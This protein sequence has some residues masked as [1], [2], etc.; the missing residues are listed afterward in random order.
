MSAPLKTGPR[1]QALMHHFEGL[2][3]RA[4]L[5]PARVWTIGYGNTFYADG[6]PVRSGDSITHQ[7]A[8]EIF[9]ATLER[10]FEPGVQRA[11]GDAATTP[12][13]FG[14]M[15]ALAYNIGVRAFSRSKVCS[16]HVAGRHAEAADAFLNW[17]RG[18][19]KELP[20]L[21]RRRQAER[22]LYLNQLA[23]LDRMLG[24]GQ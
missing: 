5:C 1:A 4:Y 22:L 15:V 2:R 24:F 14:A 19:G 13:Q 9:A 21:V 11:I 17:T 23:E 8:K 18:G 20:G 7:E 6:R 12:A 16:L 10:L 3:L